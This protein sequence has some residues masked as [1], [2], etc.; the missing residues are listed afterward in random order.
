MVFTG[1]LSLLVFPFLFFI[2]VSLLPVWGF[3]FETSFPLLFNTFARSPCMVDFSFSFFP[4]TLGKRGREAVLRSQIKGKQDLWQVRPDLGERDVLIN[5]PRG[6]K[7]GGLRGKCATLPTP[8]STF[9][10][11]LG[12]DGESGNG[13]PSPGPTY[14]VLLWLQQT[15]GTLRA[16][17]LQMQRA[18]QIWTFV[19]LSRNEHHF[20]LWENCTP[21]SRPSSQRHPNYPLRSLAP[22]Q[23]PNRAYSLFPFFFPLTTSMAL[24]R[25]LRNDS[26]LFL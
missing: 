14:P 25:G 24:T 19:H 8:S 26:G 18:S 22:P 11:Y 17:T 23:L 9:R 16:V 13:S 12:L 7:E 2:F 20:S 15:Q 10:D 6:G 3:S 1:D 4:P 21:P 5:H